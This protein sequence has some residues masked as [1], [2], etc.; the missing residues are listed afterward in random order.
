MN[1]MRQKFRLYFRFYFQSI[2]PIAYPMPPKLSRV[3]DVRLPEKVKKEFKKLCEAFDMSPDDVSAC[4]ERVKEHVNKPIV[5][6]KT[7]LFCAVE[8]AAQDLSLIQVKHHFCVSC[9]DHNIYQALLSLK[10]VQVDAPSD[11]N[12]D[13]PLIFALKSRRNDLVELLL[14]TRADPCKCND[15]GVSA[16]RIAATEPDSAV[17]FESVLR[18]SSRE[19]VKIKTET[20]VADTTLLHLAATEACT[21]QLKLLL[22]TH[23]ELCSAKDDVRFT[24]NSCK[25]HFNLFQVTFIQV[26]RTPLHAASE[27]GSIHC[28]KALLKAS[29]NIEAIDCEG[30]TPMH[31]AL[32]AE[33]LNDGVIAALKAAGCNMTA[34][35]LMGLTCA[36]VEELR[37]EVA[38]DIA[39]KEEKLREEVK[40]K[41][42]KK[43][44]EKLAELRDFLETEA[45]LD[46]ASIEALMITG[47]VGSMD[48]LVKLCDSDDRL[49]K[50]MKAPKTA[51]RLQAAVRFRM[52]GPRVILYY[53]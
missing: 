49:V 25:I 31:L 32:A 21:D 5:D 51:K 37:K 26:E 8:S 1:P 33:T 28:V 34:K 4:V 43:K 47:H 7:P 23:P 30:N 42:G 15:S 48:A 14:S 10:D 45:E 17:V 11:P 27:A 22:Q 16:L 52:C 12:G 36:D 38:A 39:A 24:P 53:C 40:E 20:G 44:E 18:A 46:A 9:Y 29:A 19:G 3:S 50:L 41:Q 35:N 2:P 13:T 6:G